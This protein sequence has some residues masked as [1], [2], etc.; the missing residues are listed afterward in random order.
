MAQETT[1]ELKN[2]QQSNVYNGGA[3][4][5][6]ILGTDGHTVTTGYVN[7]PFSYNG[8]NIQ[9][10]GYDDLF[11]YKASSSGEKIWM[12]SMNAGGEGRIYPTYLKENENGQIM[13]IAQ[14][15]GEI[16]INNSTYSSKSGNW[17]V[18]KLDQSGNVIYLSQIANLNNGNNTFEIVSDSSYDYVLLNKSL[19]KMDA[20]NG[21]IINNWTDSS[22]AWSVLEIKNDKLYIGAQVLTETTIEE[23]F[24]QVGDNILLQ[25]DTGFNI[26][27]II[28]FGHLYDGKINDILATQNKLIVTGTGRGNQYDVNIGNTT[29][30]CS[31]DFD[32]YTSFIWTIKLDL[33]LTQADWFYGDSAIIYNDTYYY[34]LYPA[35]GDNFALYYSNPQQDG[36]QISFLAGAPVYFNGSI[37]IEVDDLGNVVNTHHHYMGIKT[38]NFDFKKSGSNEYIVCTQDNITSSYILSGDDF[39]LNKNYITTNKSASLKSNFLEY[40]NGNI[41]SASNGKGSIENYFGENISTDNNESIDIFSKFSEN[42]NIL[43]TNKVEGTKQLGNV[44]YGVFTN[45]V[46]DNGS[47]VSVSKCIR[48]PNN[49]T[50]TI[51]GV[52]QDLPN[53]SNSF[54]VTYFN[55]DGSLKWNK[56]VRSPYPELYNFSSEINVFTDKNDNV[57]LFGNSKEN[58]ILENTDLGAN[59]FITK[60]NK[61]GEVVFTKKLMGISYIF[62]GALVFDENNN[63]YFLFEPIDDK[64][65]T[66]DGHILHSNP[67]FLN[68]YLVKFDP[69]GN[70]I[71]GKN[72]YADLPEG[73]YR[74]SWPS[75]FKYDGE[76]LVIYDIMLSQN[77]TYLGLNHQGFDNVYWDQGARYAN[78]ISKINKNGDVLWTTPIISP[79]WNGDRIA[80]DSQKNIY[81]YGNYPDKIT[82][83]NKEYN[84]TTNDY[85]TALIKLYSDGQAAVVEP[86]LLNENRHLGNRIAVKENG[87]VFISGNAQSRKIQDKNINNLGGDNY[88]IGY[89]E[90]QFLSTENTENLK[91]INIYPNPTTDFINILSDEKI[92]DSEIFDA[93]GRKIPI[94]NVSDKKLDV[95]KLQKGVYFLRIKTSKGWITNKFIKK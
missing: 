25:T 55:S 85:S 83:Q 93:S 58:L 47:I 27:K 5:K 76:N 60:L 35:G 42:G 29:A 30:H 31:L 50:L 88:I 51:N 64:D 84:L 14:F 67:N 77:K 32:T 21:S 20:A 2:L 78:S 33:E 15:Q 45:S 46:T 7:G 24:F 36:E 90:E 44:D 54:I 74:Y 4:V 10:I 57:Y 18:L 63:A 86:L 6:I 68:L 49:C 72:F 48:Y 39:V 89:L 61:E 73:D 92:L 71:F 11:V 91:Q 8:E 79:L 23:Q 3:V 75:D 52:S 37:L 95:K 66:I 81:T 13:I 22:L 19:I 80:F 62:E 69:S 34:H 56:V 16:N 12:K 94:S 9:A 82:I 59:S 70:Y 28:S 38:M 40:K 43:W 53:S 1:F 26:D 65:I 17:F 87:K 41:Y